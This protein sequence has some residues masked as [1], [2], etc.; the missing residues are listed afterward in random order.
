MFN[1]CLFKN[2]SSFI[3]LT[4]N[5]SMF[6]PTFQ[7]HCCLVCCVII[8]KVF[9][10]LAGTLPSLSDKSFSSLLSSQMTAHHF[11][12]DPRGQFQGQCHRGQKHCLKMKC[13]NP[14][15]QMYRVCDT[16]PFPPMRSVCSS[17]RLGSFTWG[18]TTLVF[19]S[20]FAVHLYT[21]LF[22]I[23]IFLELVNSNLN[24]LDSAGSLRDVFFFSKTKINKYT[25]RPLLVWSCQVLFPFI[26]YLILLVY[27]I[28]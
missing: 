2:I 28:I 20:I 12:R 5:C 3:S 21:D 16:C 26:T 8:K 11:I 4:A 19:W 6:W 10:Y 14:V 13:T 22:N 27:F 9:G 18:L 7:C 15:F 24:Y 17:S 1:L 23:F 25:Y